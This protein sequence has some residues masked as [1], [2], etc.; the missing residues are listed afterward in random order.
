[1]SDSNITASIK[2]GVLIVKMPLAKKPQPSSSGKNLT[3]ASTR[4]NMR[5][6]LEY[7]GKPITIGINAYIPAN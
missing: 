2:E 6:D 1:M 5:L 4:G 3:V 7:Q